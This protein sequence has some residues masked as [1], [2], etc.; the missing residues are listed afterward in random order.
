MPI[1]R[2]ACRASLRCPTP[3]CGSTSRCRRRA[4][5]TRRPT[6]TAAGRSRFA[7]LKRQAEQL[8]GWL[9]GA[10]VERGD[11][12]ALYLQNCPQFV[13]AFYAVMRADAVVVP[14]NPMNRADEFE[15]YITD[16][17]TKVVIC[18]AD[19]AGFVAAANAERAGRAAPEAGARDALRRRAAGCRVAEDIA[20][21]PAIEQWL[22]AE[23]PLPEGFV[24]WSDALAAGLAPG[25]QLAKTRRP[26]VAALHLGHDRA[27]QGLHAHPPHA[28]EQRRR[29]P[30]GLGRR[31]ERRPGGG[32][33]V[34]HHRHDVRRARF[35]LYR[36]D[37]GADAALGPRTRRA[38]D[39]ALPGDALDVHPDDDHRPLRRARTTGA[40]TCRASST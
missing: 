34:P 21:P 32:A 25:P 36:L 17:D 5:P 14:V 28:D 24:R 19:L 22:R 40:S 38:T 11:R 10:G 13:V 20:L 18:A 39:L 4:S 8:A 1:G 9:Q 37:A 27:A 7:E 26:G 6:S 23:S 33:D 3:R 29:R 12:V 2:A 16:P 31:R 15:H 35:G 30:V